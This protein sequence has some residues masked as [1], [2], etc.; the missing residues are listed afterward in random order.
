MPS[1]LALPRFVGK[2]LARYLS[3]PRASGQI[4]TPPDP[5]KL[6]QCLQPCDVLL[7]EGSSRISTAIKYLTQST[8]SHATLFVGPQLGGADEAGHP[9]LFVEADIVRGVCKRS[10]AHYQPY[11]TRICRS[12][13]LGDDDRARIVADVTSKIGNQYDMKN[14]FDLARYMFPMPP[15]PQRW[16]RKLIALG[17]GDPTRAI[18]SSLIAEAFQNVGYPVLPVVTHDLAPDRRQLR[19]VVREIFHI[20]HHSLYAPRDFDVSPYFEIVKPTLARG[21]DYRQI[22]WEQVAR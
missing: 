16:R 20:R 8:W 19:A 17:S 1:M 7:V 22:E 5:R 6:L 14:V 2:A 11:H 9:Y 13:H 15:V 12:R 21:F 4:G 3:T 10:L 18:C